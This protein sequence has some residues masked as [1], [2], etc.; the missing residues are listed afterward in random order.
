MRT[1]L[2]DYDNLL[3]HRCGNKVERPNYRIT[4]A[5]A[6]NCVCSRCRKESWAKNG[7]IPSNVNAAVIVTDIAKQVILGSVLG[8]GSLERPPKGSKN[9]GL[10]IKHS[11][12][13][14]KYLRYKYGL[15]GG[16]AG[17]IDY[18]SERVRLRC[19]R[20]PFFT[21]LAK[22]FVPGKKK[23]FRNNA[24]Q[25]IGPL[26]LAIW[27]MDDGNLTP[28]YMRKNGQMDGPAIRFCTH[29]CTTT[30]R[31]A[32]KRLLCRA[33]GV[34]NP[35]DCK[36]KNPRKPDEPYFGIRLSKEDVDVF[37]NVIRP[38]IGDSGMEYKWDTK[39]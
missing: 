36:W 5:K 2:I 27:Y 30:D 4:Y 25:D 32:L 10:G 33:A 13:Q 24:M 31:A 1:S 8:D 14:E 35:M 7:K 21:G 20:H 15:I 6:K 26:G 19:I 29:I 34:K 3:C 16:L 37:L 23:I 18:P 11:L 39:C 9:W 12:N 38:F 17:K 22:M 28:R